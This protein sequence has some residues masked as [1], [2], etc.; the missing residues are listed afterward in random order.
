ME[1]KEI[2]AGT[3]IVVAD[4]GFVYV[5]NVKSDGQFCV[6]ENAH[7]IRRWGTSRGLGELALEGPKEGTNLDPV[8]T[9][10]IPARAVISIIDTEA[11]KWPCLK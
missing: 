10:R 7:N 6:V 8:G 4:R 9:V 11:A 5:G 2:L 3:A 1:K